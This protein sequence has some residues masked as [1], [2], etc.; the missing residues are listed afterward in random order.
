MLIGSRALAH[1]VP[2]FK[3]RQS[4]DWDYI[5]MPD[6][7]PGKCEIH[8]LDQLNNEA[9]LKYDVGGVCSLK[10]LALI[11]RSHLHRDW[12]FDKH[13]AM[14]HKWILP[15]L[16]EGFNQDDLDFLAERTRLTKIEYPRSNPNLNQ[17]NEDFFD[18]AVEKKYDHDW[19]HEL[20][21]YGDA[22]VYEKLKT[23]KTK[24]WCEKD[25]FF[26][27]P[28]DEMLKCVAEETYVIATERFLIPTNYEHY[29]KLAYVK[30]LRKVCTTLTSGWFRDYAIDN[31]PEIINHYDKAKIQYV[32]EQL[33]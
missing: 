4:A 25:L 2:D 16:K 14:Y 18:D 12:F 21:A 15:N 3:C 17:S 8:P 32:K 27:L 10:G 30:A 1:W 33:K 24:A 26:L 31:Y 5:G 28:P 13:I 9:A 6:S 11:K 20:Y 19:L 23:D 22:P 29:W 7:K